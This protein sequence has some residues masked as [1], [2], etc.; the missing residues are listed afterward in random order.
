MKY[1]NDKERP[2]ILENEMQS[3][4]IFSILPKLRGDI[5]KEKKMF[6]GQ[7]RKITMNIDTNHKLLS[8]SITSIKSNN[9]NQDLGLLGKIEVP[10]P[11]TKRHILIW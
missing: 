9:F 2:T 6:E 1:N 11:Q 3:W 4:G 10:Y 5:E 8:H 7:N